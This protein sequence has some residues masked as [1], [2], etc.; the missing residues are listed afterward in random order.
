MRRALLKTSYRMLLRR[1][2]QSFLMLLGVALGVAVFIAID[3]A[4][5]SAR[6]SFELSTEALIGRATHQV[7]GG[8]TGIAEDLY[9]ELRVELGFRK[10]APVVEGLAVAVDFEDHILQ[11]LGIDPFAEASFR[12]YLNEVPYFQAGFEA[13]YTDPSSVIVSEAF[14]L[15][16]DLKPGDF[17]RLQV[18]QRF[19][20]MTILAL[21]AP[22]EGELTAALDNILLMD[23]AAAQELT[24]SL[25]RLSRI[26]LILEKDEI[27]DLEQHLP[28]GVRLQV[29]SEQASAA[30]QLTSA[31]ELN[32][33]A[34]SLLTLAVGMFMI[35][36][37]MMFSVVQRRTS[38]G[39]LRTLGVT[40]NQ[41]LGMIMF[42][43]GIIG[44]IGSILGIILG[45]R[46][47][48]GAIQLVSQTI[49]DLY[50][51]V[52]VRETAITLAVLA[53]AFALGIFGSLLAGTIPALEAARVEPVSALRRSDL[54][55]RVRVLI[56]GLS[57]AGIVL[58]V[59]S[60]ILMT[61]F[62]RWLALN[63]AALFLMILGIAFLV[64]RSVIM[65][66]RMAQRPMS[67][68]FGI[69]GRLAVRAVVMG[70]SRTSVA[71]A[72]FTISLAVTIGVSVMISSF[73]ST[74]G[75][76][77]ETTLQADLY[78]TAP[79]GGGTRLIAPLAPEIADV[80]EAIEGV[81][82][83]ETFLS[84][85][86]ASPSGPVQLSVVDV[87]RT[88]DPSIFRKSNLSPERIWDRVLEGS[89]IVT[90]PF[91]Y[92]FEIQPTGDQVTLF[93]DRGERS[94]PV[95]GIYFD[96]SSDRGA[97]LMSDQ[98]YRQFWDDPSISSLSI[99][100]G[101]G[102]QVEVVA[103]RIRASIQG[104][105]LVVQENRTI[106]E[107]AL[108][109]FDRTFAV[110][111]ALRILT[112]VIA[113]I[114][115]LSSLLALILE[116]GRAQAT[117]QALGMAPKGLIK[118][119]LLESGL[120]GAT[121]GIL[122]WPAGIL[123][124]IMLIYVINQRSFGWTMDMQL[125]PTPFYQALVVGILAAMIAAIYPIILLLRQSVAES[126]RQE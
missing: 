89:V 114:G 34:L 64:P 113:F 15:R 116:R 52:N 121:A 81:Q 126:L 28:S 17:L 20:T 88:R 92:H 25:G 40:P 77:L 98:T 1:P 58:F 95:V 36:N 123:M 85:A 125:G 82:L 79:L 38:L 62:P 51:V 118:T 50:Y 117:I 44:A 9:R 105:G 16:N 55:Q 94:F 63:F 74:V 35:Y 42:E 69:H 96:Y 75:N 108:A 122:A 3:V 86:I 93:T 53:K 11:I 56:P 106:R 99:Y 14:A 102:E 107:Q 101:E 5:Q 10:S 8:P 54:E 115:V 80:F 18:N 71:I 30:A 49:N 97:I 29:A 103:G 73:R 22:R 13:F 7:R 119:M 39:I 100:I 84:V 83:V 12:S 24:G 91:A 112:I 104:R 43:A 45:L 67:F 109:I 60:A 120:M 65:F 78:V 6:R 68:M 72:A 21:L 27:A 33:S 110:T 46:L 61:V 32:L 47:G 31:F 2:L 48:Q 66:M 26:D 87:K 90:E 41:I 4:N 23:I 70:L 59:I 111:N 76:W 57:R 19:E 124:S 37:S